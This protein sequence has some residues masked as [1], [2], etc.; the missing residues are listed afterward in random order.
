M[1]DAQ[2]T[3]I[4]YPALAMF[5]L[6]AAVFVRMAQVRFGAVGRGEMQA[7]FYRT[8]QTGAEP[9]YMRVVTRNFIN[10]FE[11]PVLFYVAVI[12]I[13]VTRQTSPWFLGCAWTYVAL[14]YL[15]TYVHLGRNDVVLRFRIYLASWVVLTVA[16][17]SLFVRL[18]S[19]T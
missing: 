11:V 2:S 16:W 4:L 14:R 9:D 7:E 19:G 17:V 12:L 1:A 3:S 6:T 5:L 13:Y 18:G 15:H 10:L 8:Y